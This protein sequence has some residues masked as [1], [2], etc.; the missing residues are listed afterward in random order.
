MLE[1]L[2]LA[3]ALSMDAF[4][5]AIGLGAKGGEK[6]LGLKVG[7]FFGMF[8]A[9]MPLIGYLGGQQLLRWVADYDQWIAFALL[10]FIG[11][12]MIREGLHK[13][14]EEETASVTTTKALLLLAIATSIDAM[15]AGFSFTLLKFNP[16]LACIIIGVTT[17][18]FSWGGVEIGRRSG[19]KL[20]SKAEILG[21][22]VLILI[23]L[24]MLLF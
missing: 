9:L 20:G 14:E 6:T 19:A 17:F 10:A 5:V 13:D 23:G 21:G 8:Q 16:W 12:K 11:A 18:V 3:V 4:A 2:I 22:V 24:K 7:L 15:A 1:V